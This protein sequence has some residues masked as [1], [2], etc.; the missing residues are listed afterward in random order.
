M[1]VAGQQTR[2]PIPVSG[3]QAYL[4]ELIREADN[5]EKSREGSALGLN[6]V[7][8]DDVSADLA[9]SMEELSALF[10]E[11]ALKEVARRR[12]GRERTAPSAAFAKA[13]GEW[14]SQFADMPGRDFL[15]R[16]L[17]QMRQPGSVPMT[18]KDLLKALARGSGDPSHQFA[19][20]DILEK[21]LGGEGDERLAQTVR[22]AKRMLSEEKGAEVRAGI[23]IAKEVNARAKTPEQMQDLRN[24]YRSETLGFTSPQAC[25]RSLLASRGPERLG[26]SLDF[27]L[28]SCGIDL[29][30]PSPSQSPE[31][32]RR[33]LLDLQCVDVL[34]AMLERCDALVGKM[35]DV[36]GETS[37]LN[38]RQLA[39]QLTGLT[40]TPFPSAGNFASLL[41]SCGF[42]QL[43]AKIYFNTQLLE[44]VRA[45]S[46]RL[47]A[48]DGDRFKLIDAAQENLD[49]LV[50]EEDRG[51]GGKER[52]A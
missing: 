52:A 16:V 44:L 8:M 18:A 31:E 24:L 17:R 14:A 39:E 47:F 28:K 19:M 32:L 33:I 26:E 20:L 42:M 35:P 27:L 37:L 10:E 1:I 21:A 36:F 49:G 40:E 12:L 41:Q 29:Q 50:K 9:D 13:L 45:L 48:D 30:N 38:G 25:F 4:G 2:E 7:A 34:K 46:P 11:Q 15:T 43:V 23:N 3:L 22:E 5:L 51:S 6:L